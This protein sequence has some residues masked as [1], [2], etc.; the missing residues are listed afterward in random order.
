MAYGSRLRWG[1]LCLFAW[2][3]V[4][5]PA[6]SSADPVGEG[7]F[8]R[9]GYRVKVYEG[10]W[11]KDLDLDSAKPLQTILVTDFSKPT[12]QF[13][14]TVPK[15][16]FAVI[17]GLLYIREPQQAW[18]S[19]GW[20]QT[21]TALMTVDGKEVYRKLP[22]DEKEVG[23]EKLSIPLSSRFHPFRIIHFTQVDR[24]ICFSSLG[25]LEGSVVH[26][27]MPFTPEMQAE[28]VGTL[29][30]LTAVA[31]GK[32]QV[33]DARMDE[34][35]RSIESHRYIFGRTER[36]MRAALDF[37]AAHD[38]NHEYLFKTKHSEWGKA[39][40]TGLR[41]AVFLTMQY[42]MDHAYTPQNL[43]KYPDLLGG[44]RFASSEYFP[45]PVA[46]PT[47]ANAGY[48]VKVWATFPE[49]APQHFWLWHNP[50]R[51]PTGAYL[52]PGTIATVTVPQS[53]VNKG[54]QIRVGAHAN[55]LSAKPKINRLWRSSLQYP[56]TST[57]VRIAS[58]LGGGIYLE[59]PAG[60]DQGEVELAF[61][62]IVR[63]PFYS[64]TRVRTTTL[65]A[66]QSVESR[67][68]APWAD[69]Q[70]D[71]F[72]M[73]LPRNWVYNLKDPAALMAEWDK[74]VIAVVKVLGYTPDEVGRETFYIQPDTQLRNT[75]FSPGHPQVNSGGVVAA[76][77]TF[78]GYKAHDFHLRGPRYAPDWV[79]HELGHYVN[80]AGPPGETES[81]N[82]FL[83][84]VA[85]NWG[86]GVPMDEAFG[87]SRGSKNSFSTLDNTA[88]NWMTGLNFTG[89]VMASA[90]KSYQLK[91]H[92]K[93]AHVA[94]LFGWETL[95][96]FYRT[97]NQDRIGFWKSGG[98]KGEDWPK[99][100]DNSRFIRRMS[101][102]SG[103]D[104]RP[105]FHFWGTPPL[106]GLLLTTDLARLDAEV[107]QAT[108][109]LAAAQAA[110]AGTTDAKVDGATEL[111]DAKQRLADA[112][113][114]RA[115]HLSSL[116]DARKEAADF[117]AL[118]KS[119][120]VKRSA[121]IYDELQRYKSLVPQDNAAFR[122]Y[123]LKWYQWKDGKPPTGKVFWTER[124]HRTQ[125]DAYNERSAA[126]IRAAIDR[127]I[128]FYFPDGRPAE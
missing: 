101:M 127:M 30:E 103:S 85:L 28:L 31:A 71:V 52:A 64:N 19:P 112:E 35:V 12:Q 97:V 107:K 118:I 55:D 36:I 79:F 99:S 44:T 90:Q 5:V 10:P 92:A 65:E 23:G 119:G 86:L 73:Q 27:A 106:H 91:G 104:I 66:W 75:V 4:G 128:A 18:F 123:A 82:N 60:A 115:K 76:D 87:T 15:D 53:L 117:D 81:S 29:E 7:Q 3:L 42:L 108:A 95:S 89:G 67:H 126:E 50:A 77:D 59:V 24:L 39:D 111:D 116:E 70:S 22:T 68:P 94:H 2:A 17:E 13:T 78:Q 120:K 16:G 98:T 33:P 32:K 51:K 62:N 8:V 105:L 47:D 93:F 1:I 61:R 34:L 114:V 25:R 46:K 100:I 80:L 48:S 96:D 45:G 84:A 38:A 56:V 109:E 14:C 121:K 125:W 69:F 21:K 72:M 88:V 63:S 43:A 6:L 9:P 74:S 113:A 37:V 26:V 110:K 54:F 124:D 58:P 83:H 122:T 41:W 57:E 102:T 11:Q 40:R 20:S 49:T